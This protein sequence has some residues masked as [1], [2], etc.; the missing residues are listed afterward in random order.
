MYYEVL[1][2]TSDKDSVRSQ[3]KATKQ[4][5]VHFLEDQ[6]GNV[7]WIIPCTP[8]WKQGIHTVK[9][10]RIDDPD[11]F[12]EIPG[13]EILGSVPVDENYTQDLIW[14]SLSVDKESKLALV[15][16]KKFCVFL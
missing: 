10:F 14:D 13:L 9:L 7:D 11:F 1:T 12:T 4:E 6:E 5:G 3:I 16:E 2:Y 15:A 8:T